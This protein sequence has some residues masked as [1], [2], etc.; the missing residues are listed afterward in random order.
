MT[1]KFLSFLAVFASAM[2]FATEWNSLLVV[3]EAQKA[4]DGAYFGE[5][6]V[7]DGTA[8]PDVATRVWMWIQEDKL[9]LR[10]EADDPLMSE[11]PATVTK[12]DGDVWA[13]DSIDFFIKPSNG[14]VYHF[15][16]NA[17]GTQ[18]DACDDDVRWNGDWSVKVDREL[19]AW[20][21]D[22]VI[23]LNDLG[24]KPAVGDEWGFQFG[25]CRFARNV[26]RS[27]CWNPTGTLRFKDAF[28]TIRFG[29][30]NHPVAMIP[31]TE[32]ANQPQYLW[33]EG[34]APECRK[35][36]TV[37]HDGEYLTHRF[38][39]T[40]GQG[41]AVYRV[42]WVK[43]TS[44]VSAILK[45]ALAALESSEEFVDRALVAD[46]RVLMGVN[47]DA[48]PELCALLEEEATVLR[49]R[50]EYRLFSRE[51][52][53]LGKPEDGIVYGIQNTL[54][55]MRPVDE[56]SGVIGGEIHLDSAR[57]EMEA[58]Q[59][60]V[61][62]GEGQLHHVEA[63][64]SK[65][66]TNADGAEIPAECLRV[67][68]LGYVKTCVPTYKVDYVGLY[69]DPLMPATP[70]D[71]APYGDET[72]WVDV[73][74][75]PDAAPGIY[76][77]TLAIQSRNAD[78]TEIPVTLRVRN[79]NIP[80]K[81][82][83]VSA[84]GAWFWPSLPYVVDEWA[85]YEDMLEHRVTPYS[86]ART[87]KMVQKP[88]LQLGESDALEI[89][90]D[91]K[92]A[93]TL[94]V[95]LKAA[96]GGAPRTLDRAILQG[97]NLVR[98]ENLSELLPTGRLYKVAFELENA[99]GAELSLA[100]HRGADGSTL[101]LLPATFHSVVLGRDG[102]R[103]SW[104]TW[105][106][107]AIGE[108]TTPPVMDWSEFDA[109]VQ[110][111]LDLGITAHNTIF[112][113]DFEVWI[114]P[115]RDHLVEKGWIDL[116]YTY[117]ADEPVPED[118]PLV[119]ERQ[120]PVKKYAGT[121]LMN[122][123]TARS[124]PPELCFVDTWCPEVYSFNPEGAAAEQAKNRNVWWY[125][126]FGARPPYPNVWID[127]PITETRVW[128]WQTWKHDLDG[129]LY[130]SVNW[131]PLADPWRTGETFKVS[132][133]D[134]NFLYP[135]AS[136]KPI[137]SIRWEVLRDGFEDY[138]L[139]CMLEAARDEIGDGNPALTER[140]STLL[141]VNPEVCVSWEEY[142]YDAAKILSERVKLMDCLEEA[143][144]FLGHQPEIT[145][146]PRRRPGMSQAEI[147]AAVQAFRLSE[148]ARQRKV[149]EEY[150]KV[151]DANK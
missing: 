40:D 28:G 26:A 110:R 126:A 58:V 64:F 148:D 65:P 75:A 103:S 141:A 56:F 112:G 24:G 35:V 87:P 31:D 57:N 74:V 88:F 22:V 115:Y 81:S 38:E 127:S 149:A 78:L 123:M 146:R 27:F 8:K 98:L 68:R 73:V 96:D 14:K 33:S 21:S 128:L 134:G 44:R 91:S 114:K 109:D 20:K 121:D 83:I 16:Y 99:P 138:E 70:F 95:S 137:A 1:T 135:D 106:Y 147:D 111:G 63:R 130:W 11:I 51:M 5:L 76:K 116:F 108:G 72:L 45:N 82:S 120:E 69:P 41:G 4:A 143:V 61:F 49:H 118:Y 43:R 46:A 50:M 105:E 29:N 90:V 25:R 32:N 48:T 10:V 136:G 17:I 9:H 59:V 19:Y 54:V 119:N 94:K 36:E 86:V 30:A 150:Q 142:T 62:A 18:F 39:F 140:I 85:L 97:E 89:S 144:A 7:V 145:R 80:R 124:F 6:V 23:D 100:L 132:N 15:I 12:R 104:P 37:E 107:L 53:R 66:L 52:R 60:T 122:M 129:I 125:V 113:E 77:G 13:D 2:L 42:N 84:F 93:G 101:E 47:C 139:F 117:L 3:P 67:R 133:G 34:N 55:R 131:W 151:L 71:V 92:M 102:E 79:F